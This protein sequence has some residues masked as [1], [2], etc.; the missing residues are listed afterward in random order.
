MGETTVYYHDGDAAFISGLSDGGNAY[1]QATFTG[2]LLLTFYWKISSELG[3]DTLSL[4][5]DGVA[6]EAISGEVDWRRRTV[7]IPAG[8]HQMR[9]WYF[10]DSSGSAGLDT[11]WVDYVTWAATDLSVGQWR[12]RTN[13]GRASHAMAYDSTRQKTLLFGGYYLS[14]L[15][16][17]WEW[18]GSAWTQMAATGPSAR[19]R[20]I[21]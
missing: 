4:Y 1:L 20:A 12:A 2:P 15:G 14:D 13:P 5:M 11:A 17:T 7:L 10:K 18:D 19:Q 16:D 6:Q 3:K 21:R 8:S 9:W